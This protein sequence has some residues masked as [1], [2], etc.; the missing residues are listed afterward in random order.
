MKH[1]AESV[2]VKDWFDEYW[3]EE[4]EAGHIQG[5]IKETAQRACMAL[6][7][8]GLIEWTGEKHD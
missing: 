8:S 1:I 2:T 5:D 3:K 7:E 6:L 4:S